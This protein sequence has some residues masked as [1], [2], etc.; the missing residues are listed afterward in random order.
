MISASKLSVPQ[1]RAEL[2]AR[3][4]SAEGKRHDLYRRV[5]VRLQPQGL[6]RTPGLGSLKP[7]GVGV[8]QPSLGACRRPVRQ[9]RGR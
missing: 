7:S 9:R 3:G 6:N 5:Q 2:I 1:L 8:W 4:L